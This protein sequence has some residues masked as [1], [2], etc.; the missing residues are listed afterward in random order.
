VTTPTEDAGVESLEPQARSRIEAL[1]ARQWSL[2]GEHPLARLH[3][4]S[5]G[6]YHILALLGPKNNVGSRYFQLWLSD[7]DGLLSEEPLAL[8]LHNSGPFPAF[9][10]IELA[11]YR[12]VLRV[13]DDVVDLRT[14]SLEL[15]LFEQLA[16]FVPPGGHIMVEYDSP[17]QR[18]TERILTLGNPPVCSPLGYLMFRIG[19][20]SYRDW[21]ISEGGR[22]GPRKLQGFM[23][24]NDE[25]R[26][27]KEERLRRELTEF[28]SRTGTGTADEWAAVAR[29]IASEVLR[30]L[31]QAV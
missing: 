29:R 28:L 3:G 25:V 30:E 5:L 1:L 24:L 16:L 17:S 8:G 21:Y 4:A 12:E 11:Q 23:P 22:E 13:A 9:N 2:P 6:E 10:W 20:R 26:R 19:C 18:A 15:T 14:T 7:G 31:E 27:E